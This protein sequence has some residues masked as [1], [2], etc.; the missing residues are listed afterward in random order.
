MTKCR[1]RAHHWAIQALRLC[2]LAWFV[3]VALAVAAA[4]T[5]ILGSTWAEGLFKDV[6]IAVVVGLV[7]V[8]LAAIAAEAVAGWR[9]RS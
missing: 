9:E 7:P 1:S 5:L 3:A 6:Y 8:T 2:S 4:A